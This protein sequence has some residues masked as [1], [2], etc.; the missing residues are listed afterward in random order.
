MT[1]DL[2]H[3][4]H[5]DHVEGLLVGHRRDGRSIYSKQGKRQ[6]VEMCLRPGTSLAKVALHHGLNANVLRRWV[7][8]AAGNGRKAGSTPDAATGEIARMLP[9]VQRRSRAT[10]AMDTHCSPS[11]EIEI[12]GATVRLRG[13]VDPA[14]L[15]QV[16]DC[17][18][19]A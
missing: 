6:L 4:H 17:L 8:E 9:V 5:E 12:A 10:G 1:T 14:Q 7:T 18:M 11:I 16:L 13:A 3:T 2:M 15:R 19:R